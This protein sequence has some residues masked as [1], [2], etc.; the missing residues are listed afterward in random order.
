LDHTKVYNTGEKGKE[1]E[2][3]T[4]NRGRSFYFHGMHVQIGGSNMIFA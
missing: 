2:Q 1:K 4:E 3:D